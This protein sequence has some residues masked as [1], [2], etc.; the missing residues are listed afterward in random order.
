MSSVRYYIKKAQFKLNQ[1]PSQVQFWSNLYER[2][3]LH[4]PVHYTNSRGSHSDSHPFGQ[5]CH[6]LH[7]P[8]V[9]PSPNSVLLSIRVLPVDNLREGA[10]VFG[11]PAFEDCLPSKEISGWF[12]LG[13]M[14][15][16]W[17]SWLF[18][19]SSLNN[20]TFQKSIKSLASLLH[21]PALAHP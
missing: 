1:S 12:L 5:W 4:L 11:A 13:W 19:E 20:A 17:A 7:S 9:A 18:T 10:K 21:H 8:S 16:F 14:L 3:T 15:D 6:L 2:S